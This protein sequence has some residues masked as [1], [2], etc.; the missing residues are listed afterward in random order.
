MQQKML[1]VRM[2]GSTRDTSA[3]AVR[4]PPEPGRRI[5]MPATQAERAAMQHA[6]ALAKRGPRGLNPQVGAMILSPTGAVLAEGWHRGTGTNHAEID[7]L[8]KLE[9]AQ[10]RGAT[11]VVTL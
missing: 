7:A 4:P 1:R 10:T 11:A 5:R 3:V 6:L 8:A 9:P 2:G